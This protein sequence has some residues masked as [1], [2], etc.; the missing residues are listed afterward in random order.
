MIGYSPGLL[1]LQLWCRY[2][3]QWRPS[4]LCIC[5]EGTWGRWKYS[6]NHSHPQQ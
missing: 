3:V 4:C 6:S 1:P 5:H 2:F